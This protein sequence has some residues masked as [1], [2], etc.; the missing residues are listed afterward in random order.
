MNLE[1]ILS[2]AIGLALAAACGLRVFAPIFL[3]GLAAHFGRLHLA[4]GF[5]WASTTPALVALGTATV[6]EIVA[7]YVP[8]LDHA[9]D[10]ISA[11]AA[12]MAGAIATV[13]VL[14]D[15]PPWLR[16][17]TGLIAGGGLAGLAKGASALLRVKSRATTGGLANPVVAT[18][19]SA[20]AVGI[21]LLALVVPLLALALVV[22]MVVLVFRAA[23]HIAF[24][25]RR[26]A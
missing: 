23:H 19:E 17:T 24:G 12:L 15:L 2:V 3:L 13:A 8:W 21:S 5:A 16:W 18:G 11:P 9:L 22:I 26:T 20:G 6:V 1:L 7:Y 4:S 14:G 10:V 25:G